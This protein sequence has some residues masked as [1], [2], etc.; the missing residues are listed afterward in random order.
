MC[1]EKKGQFDSL[2]SLTVIR[3]A[4]RKMWP[5][6]RSG[7]DHERAPNREAMR[8]ES[9]GHT[10]AKTSYLV[11]MEVEM[12]SVREMTRIEQAHIFDRQLVS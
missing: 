5:E 3:L 10:E 12:A 9:N 8:R 2:R 7:E 1:Q 6:P 11:V 4:L